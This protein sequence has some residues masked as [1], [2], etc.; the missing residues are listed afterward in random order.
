MIDQFADALNRF[1]FRL[2]DQSREKGHIPSKNQFSALI[3]AL[4][5]REPEFDKAPFR[6]FEAGDFSV[7]ISMPQ[8]EMLEATVRPNS[9]RLDLKP[10]TRFHWMRP[11]E[12]SISFW[13]NGPAPLTNG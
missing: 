5:I 8:D 3:Y 12:G 9:D 7:A 6:E 11:T 10:L 4:M 2:M 13:K 1:S